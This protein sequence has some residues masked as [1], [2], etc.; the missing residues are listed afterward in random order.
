MRDASG[1]IGRIKV[2]A[3]S[4][5]ARNEAV[6]TSPPPHAAIEVDTGPEVHS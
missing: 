4:L 3:P 1:N 5:P 2:L 6:R